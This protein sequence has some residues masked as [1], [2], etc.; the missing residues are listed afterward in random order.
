MVVNAF[1]DGGSDTTYLSDDAARALG[2][3]WN[4]KSVQITTLGGNIMQHNTTEVEL[5]VGPVEQKHSEVK[6]GS[7]RFSMCG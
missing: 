4:L 6:L 5:N 1:L 2:V 7:K 3:K